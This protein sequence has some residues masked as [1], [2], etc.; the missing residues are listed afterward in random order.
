MS[1]QIRWDSKN[2]K[3]QGKA[4]YNFS[5]VQGT[6]FGMTGGTSTSIPGGKTA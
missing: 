2:P 4:G 6:V 1:G 3:L 5:Q